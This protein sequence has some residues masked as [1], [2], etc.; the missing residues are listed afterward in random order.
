MYKRQRERQRERGRERGRE[1]EGESARSRAR[2][3]ARTRESSQRLTASTSARYC[4]LRLSDVHTGKFPQWRTTRARRTRC[5]ITSSVGESGRDARMLLQY[6]R[7]SSDGS[8]QTCARVCAI[9]QKDALSSWRAQLAA[10]AKDAARPCTFVEGCSDA[11]IGRLAAG[12]K[13]GYSERVR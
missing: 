3:L 4:T 13:G 11:A 12:W 7:S 10:Q 8:S 2:I 1:R 6:K 5:E 9:V